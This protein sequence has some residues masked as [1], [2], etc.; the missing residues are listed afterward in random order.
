MQGEKGRP[1]W[2]G[3]RDFIVIVALLAL[4]GLFALPEIFSQ[5]SHTA[6]IYADSVLLETVSL[7]E[8]RTFSPEGFDNVMIE[9]KD[10][11]IRFLSSDCPDQ[12]CVSTGYIS[13]AGQ[14]AVCLPNRLMIKIPGTDASAPDAVTGG[15]R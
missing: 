10:G 12:V 15:V 11:A 14:Y 3:K 7:S 2:S 1:F 6:E 5:K 8:D 4:A 9:V 13:R